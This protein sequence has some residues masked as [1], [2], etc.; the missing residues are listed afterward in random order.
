MNNILPN[1]NDAPGNTPLTPDEQAKLIPSL[2]TKGELNEW[3][4]RNILDAYAWALNPRVL[5][6]EDP[7]TEPYVRELHRRMFDQTWNWAG[8]YRTTERIN[9]GIPFHEIR[10][11]IPAILADARY[12]IENKSFDVDEIA[13]RFHHRLVWIHPFPNG[14]GRHARLLADVIAVKNGREP[15]TWGREQ[16]HDGAVREEYIRL[17]QAADRDNEDIQG[18]LKFARS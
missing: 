2:A 6:R 16:L 14:N 4:R 12:Q 7:L 10:N 15:F 1:L 11:R 13:I 5:N 8:T 18:L 9:L 3:E 17:L